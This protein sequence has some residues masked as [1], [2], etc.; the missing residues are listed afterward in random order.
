MAKKAATAEQ[1]LLKL[2]EGEEGEKQRQKHPAI[3]PRK[4]PVMSADAFKGRLSFTKD[5]FKEFLKGRDMNFS[6]DLANYLLMACV[7][8]MFVILVVEIVRKP[9][10]L[11]GL[12]E[13]ISV[14]RNVEENV[15]GMKA[16]EG[17]DA[18]LQKLK[19][20]DIFTPKPKE[21][22]AVE[23]KPPVSALAQMVTKLKLVGISPAE[24]GSETYAMIENT[25]TGATFFL[26]EQEEIAGLTIKQILENRVIL[27]DG[28]DTA[29]VR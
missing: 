5:L 21:V 17:A 13:L 24:G 15:S 27:T 9:K 6:L 1:Q 12:P 2:I 3:T 19:R 4:T 14:K 29:E 11:E 8:G 25:E 20:R 22:K 23:E 7:C 28:R 26:K 10:R 16:L 18:Y